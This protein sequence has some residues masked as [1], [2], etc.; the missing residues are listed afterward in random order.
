MKRLLEKEEEAKRVEK[1]KMEKEMEEMREREKQM[2]WE[3]DSKRGIVETNEREH[4]LLQEERNRFKASC[5]AYQKRISQLTTRLSEIE[6]KNGMAKFD[7][8]SLL[9]N[10]PSISS[11]IDSR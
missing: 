10:V 11:A 8:I 3:M 1:E 2:R 7:Q 5:E 4:A 6:L 9:S